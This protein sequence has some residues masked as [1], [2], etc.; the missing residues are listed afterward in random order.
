MASKPKVAELQVVGEIVLLDPALIDATDRLRPIDPVWAEA[1]GGIM[2]AEG[3]RTPIE[4]CRLPGKAG[5]RLVTGAHR[6]SGATLKGL[7][8]RAEIVDNDATDRRLRE[9]SEN[10]HRRDLDP[11]DR[12]TFVA[13]LVDVHKARAGINRE[14][15]GRSAS[16]NARWQQVLQ[17]EA[18]DANVTMTNAYGWAQAAAERLGYSRSKV[19][20]DLFLVRRIPASVIDALRRA[21]HPVL[22]N[23]GQ[24]RALAKLDDS[25]QRKVLGLLLHHDMQIAGAPFSS[26][27]AAI[28][29]MNDKQAPSP[30][31]KRLSAF[32]SSFGRMG[33]TEKKGALDHLARM[34]PAGFDI[35]AGGVPT[36]ETAKQLRDALSVS[37]EIIARLAA[38]DG[39]PVDDDEIERARALGQAVLMNTADLF[40]TPQGE[41]V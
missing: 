1:L 16:A 22:R 29:A 28:A 41:K 17:A 20:R 18:E 26:V 34:L 3:Q 23:A 39:D 40:R 10:L 13:E 25:A 27:S 2:A 19:E 9:I 7:M 11:I 37:F 14:Q 12:A 8:L 36:I 32:I 30:D 35:V 24:L 4:V 33:L 31:A 5:F 6:H 15:D 38:A 21:D